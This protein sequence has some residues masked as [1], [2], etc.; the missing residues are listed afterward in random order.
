[1]KKVFGDVRAANVM[2]LLALSV[3]L[4][5]TSYAAITITGKNVKN[6]SLTGADVKNNT[7]AS[8]DVK[9]RSLLSKD[10]KAGQLPAGATGPQGERG[11]QGAQGL[12]GLSGPPGL[13]GLQQVFNVATPFDSVSPKT[14]SATCPGG[15]KVVA[16][17][18]LVSGTDPSIEFQVHLTDLFVSSDL[19]TVTVRGSEDQDGTGLSWFITP[20][21][22][23]GTTQP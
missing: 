10:F 21:A 11:P 23:C 1:M 8:G 7:I 19:T 16:P 18:G 6:S 17:L 14:A 12:P 9:N 22:V 5:G 3:S 2:A 4:G 20:G 13:S 15:K